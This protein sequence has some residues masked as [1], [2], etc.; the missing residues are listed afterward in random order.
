M[1]YYSILKDAIQG[2]SALTKKNDRNRST[3][4]NEEAKKAVDKAIND[5]NKLKQK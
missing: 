4:L 3:P 1:G 5:L 2:A